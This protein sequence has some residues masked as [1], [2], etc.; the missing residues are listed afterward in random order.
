M[1]TIPTWSFSRL[2]V[3]EQC[4]Y[5]AKLAYI[6]KAPE[7]PRVS[8]RGEHPLDRGTRVH[9]DAEKFVRGQLEH[10]TKELLPFEEEFLRLR[11]LHRENKVI[12]EEEWGF[13]KDWA[14]V[15]W[16]HPQ[17]WGRSKLDAMIQLES[18]QAVIIDYKTGRM[19]GN[20]IK[21]ADQG[22]QYQLA[23]FMRFP[24]LEHVTVEFWYVDQDDMTSVKFTRDQGLR[25][26]KNINDRALRL[27]GATEF[28]P[29][30]NTFNCKWCPYG[31]RGTGLC[32]HGVDSNARVF[33]T[34]AR[35]QQAE[36]KE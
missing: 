4:P 19:A 23:A 21:H 7:P 9:E 33:N 17:I 30:P 16:N 2:A 18:N 20:E 24:S 22:Q 28:P 32:E 8:D 15:A 5:R 12:L 6:D 27:T 29:K 31:P 13:T 14:P 36:G 1:P 25:F 34:G 11:M 3:F 35:R 10:L 26:F